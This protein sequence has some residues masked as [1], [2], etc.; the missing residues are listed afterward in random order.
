MP[1]FDQS[2]PVVNVF[3]YYAQHGS[4]LNWDYL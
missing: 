3:S 2:D 1:Q 4:L